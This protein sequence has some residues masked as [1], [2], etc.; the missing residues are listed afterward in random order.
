MLTAQ[1]GTA[2]AEGTASLIEHCSI[3]AGWIIDQLRLPAMISPNAAFIK[4]RSQ[5]ELA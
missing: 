4:H 5:V 3:N 1:A 2:E